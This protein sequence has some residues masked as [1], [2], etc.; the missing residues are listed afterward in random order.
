MFEVG[1]DTAHHGVVRDAVAAAHHEPEAVVGADVVF[2]RRQVVPLR[3][4]HEVD[5]GR[6]L[7]AFG[8][9]VF[10]RGLRGEHDD[11]GPRVFGQAA[12]AALPHLESR[13][14]LGLFGYDDQVALDGVQR[15]HG[16]V[17][18]GRDVALCQHVGG[19]FADA[20]TRRPGDAR[21]SRHGRGGVVHA[22]HDVGD[23]P[24]A[25]D[26][27]DGVRDVHVVTHQLLEV[28]VARRSRRRRRVEDLL[29]AF[30][31]VRVL[32]LVV[33]GVQGV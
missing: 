16:V 21:Q 26:A 23:V 9:E 7:A 31:D 11:S 1:R 29:G 5:V 20:G 6:V 25:D 30:L 14:L 15:L 12:D 2:E 10:Q 18:E 13:L 4:G 24:F 28:D 27:D 33:D 32:H 8:A 3:E 17:D 22:H 19:H